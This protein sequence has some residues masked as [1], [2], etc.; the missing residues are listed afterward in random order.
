MDDEY[1]GEALR[2]INFLR[3]FLNISE[4][5]VP[6]TAVLREFIGNGYFE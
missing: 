4:S 1:Y 3:Y 5:D 2:I 6:S